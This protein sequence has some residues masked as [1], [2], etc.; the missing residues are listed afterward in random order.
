VDQVARGRREGVVVFLS[1]YNEPT[2]DPLFEER[3]P[4]PV[5]RGLP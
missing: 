2:V 1:N 3:V 4:A 5:R